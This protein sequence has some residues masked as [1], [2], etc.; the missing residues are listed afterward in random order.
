M[1]GLAQESLG[2]GA[3]EKMVLFFGSLSHGANA[4]AADI[5]LEEI[6]GRLT[7]LRPQR[8]WRIVIA[9]LAKEKYLDKRREPVPERVLFSGFAEEIAPIIKAAQ[10]IIAPIVSG[11]GTRFGD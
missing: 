9:G 5:I 6:A 11:S 7:R 2:L 4:Q 3:G 8:D 10:V 1:P